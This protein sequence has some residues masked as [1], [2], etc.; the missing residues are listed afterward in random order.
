MEGQQAQHRV[1]ELI[2]RLQASQ[3]EAELFQTLASPYVAS[4]SVPLKNVELSSNSSATNQRTVRVKVC[5]YICE[6][7]AVLFCTLSSMFYI[8]TTAV[9]PICYSEQ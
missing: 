4:L 6:V 1:Q 9:I 7:Y 8:V 3:Q 2:A 5:P